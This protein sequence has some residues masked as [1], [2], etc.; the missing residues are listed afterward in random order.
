M[1]CEFQSCFKDQK[2]VLLR[3]LPGRMRRFDAV[4]CEKKIPDTRLKLQ[5][6][7][8][9]C[10]WSVRCDFSSRGESQTHGRHSNEL[11]RNVSKALHESD[12][13]RGF[14]HVYLCEEKSRWISQNCFSS[15][16][17]AKMQIKERKGSPENQINI[18]LFDVNLIRRCL[19]TVNLCKATSSASQWRIFLLRSSADCHRDLCTLALT[20][21][22]LTSTLDCEAK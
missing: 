5:N 10:L 21:E 18:C 13:R 11:Q 14:R 17:L 7:P 6:S 20:V 9:K 4:S 2:L 22:L 19:Q 15:I 1:K 3:E 16:H 8:H 12:R